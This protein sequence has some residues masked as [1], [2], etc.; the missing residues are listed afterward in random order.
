MKKIGQPVRLLERR[1]FLKQCASLAALSIPINIPAMEKQNMNSTK[2]FDVIIVGGS[3]AGLAAAMGLGRALRDVLII[4]SGKPAN[5][6]TPESHNFLTHD[7]ATPAGISAIARTQVGRYNSL[8]QINGTVSS[9]KKSGKEFHVDLDDGARYHA[10]NLIFATGIVDLLPGIPGMKECWG[11]SV[12]HCPYCHGYEV[13]N[14]RTGILGNGDYAFEFGALISNWTSDLTIYTNGASTLTR[15]QMTILLAHRI[16]VVES[17]IAELEHKDGQLQRIIFK[18]GHSTEV[19]ALYTR[20]EFKQ[21]CEIPVTLGCELTPDG[22]IKVDAGQ[23]TTVPGI[24]A[25]GDNVTRVRTVA[26]AVAMG[27]TTAIN[28]NKDMVMQSFH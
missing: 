20:P 15:E 5:R 1:K 28:L 23:R 11:K 8:K 4:D 6:Y 24:Y 27:T 13:R 16:S 22:Y 2:N 12:L 25:C 19:E 9:I 14:K 18:D 26:N 21:H 17:E 3:Y 10:F 7:G